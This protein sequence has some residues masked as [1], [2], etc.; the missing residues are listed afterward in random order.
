MCICNSRVF[1]LQ[2]FSDG[3]F[4]AKIQTIT[5]SEEYLVTLSPHAKCTCMELQEMVWPCQHIL[6]WD[7]ENGVNPSRHFH[8]CW[9]THSL[10]LLY[11]AVLPSFL[12]TNCPLSV[13]CH[14]P[15]PAVVT[16]RHRMVRIESGTRSRALGNGEDLHVDPAG[17]LCLRY[18]M[19]DDS[20]RVEPF[21]GPNSA[22]CLPI[23]PVQQRKRKQS[24]NTV[25]C[26]CSKCGQVGHNKR[27]CKHIDNG[28]PDSGPHEALD[29]I[30]MH[31]ITQLAFE[32]AN[33]C[34]VAGIPNEVNIT[35]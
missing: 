3:E 6:A 13:S 16:G 34:I 29:D 9:R 23:M 28:P 26:T 12:A 7:D 33:N 35:D 32:A 15:Q 19:D 22:S 27:T 4:T 17:S 24:T 1:F 21:P 20:D 2:V 11:D 8:K 14:A 25:R 10:R 31:R 18:P 5:G 30:W